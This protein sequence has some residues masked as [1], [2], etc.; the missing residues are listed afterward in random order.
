MITLRNVL[1]INAISSGATGF[2]LVVFPGF[3][4]NLFAVDAVMP[5]AEVGIFLLVF[6]AFVL[7]ESRRKTVNVSRIYG[8]VAADT[9]WVIASALLLGIR[10]VAFSVLGNLF[11]A[12]VALW[13]AAMAYL[14]F[15]GVKQ[16]E[17]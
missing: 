10:P 13:V 4:A 12:G 6:A 3:I 8:I 11:V 7:Y 5:F 14:Q 1:L 9:L 2:L 17:A 15:R 16:I